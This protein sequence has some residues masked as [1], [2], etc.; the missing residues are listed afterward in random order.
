MAGPFIPHAKCPLQWGSRIDGSWAG[1]VAGICQLHLNSQANEAENQW[2]QRTEPPNGGSEPVGALDG[3]ED[4]NL[5]SLDRTLS[6]VEVMNVKTRLLKVREKALTYSA[7][8]WAPSPWYM[9]LRS[10]WPSFP[11]VPS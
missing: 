9:A 1:A 11:T 3:T 5:S 10:S 4:D 8:N 7:E 2:N 6:S